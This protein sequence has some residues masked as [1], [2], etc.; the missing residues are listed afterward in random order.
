MV[1][2]FPIST[3]STGT[4]KNLTKVHVR[5]ETHQTMLFPLHKLKKTPID[6]DNNN[7]FLDTH[8]TTINQFS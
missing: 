2:G 7:V 1:P 5:A 8:K 3:N 6:H 4:E